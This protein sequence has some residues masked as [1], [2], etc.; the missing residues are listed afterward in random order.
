MTLSMADSITA[1]NLPAGYGAYGAYVDGKWP[2]FAAMCVRF[3]GAYHYA[4]TVAGDLGA[5]EADCETGDLTPAEAVAWAKGKLAAGASRPGIYANASTMTTGVLPE[6]AAAGVSR[7]SVRLRSAHYG[8]GEHIC[9]PAAC[10]Q[11]PV[12]M[13]ATQWTDT[14]AGENGSQIDASMLADNFFAAPAPPPASASD[15]EETM[16]ELKTGKGQTDRM[17]FPTWPAD[18][19][20]LGDPGY[21]G[22]AP[23]AVRVA[24]HG[25]D[26]YVV[27]PAVTLTPAE[28]GVTLVMSQIAGGPFDGVSFVRLDDGG[29]VAVSW[30]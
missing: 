30:R 28:P 22:G 11:T 20:L 7:E 4:I 29:P 10:G 18:L 15:Q 3:P 19:F 1:G 26:G 24:L 14:A 23:T 17:R 6:L 27:Q 5:D 16:L 25:P 2:D 8:A 21:D 9:G 13:D 12:S